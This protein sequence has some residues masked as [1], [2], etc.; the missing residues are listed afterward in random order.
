MDCIVFAMSGEDA[1]RYGR[2]EPAA[3]IP[4]GSKSPT[5][6]SASRSPRCFGWQVATARKPHN[7]L[8]IEFQTNLKLVDGFIG[9][10]DRFYAV[11]AE[12]M[13]GVFHVLLGSSK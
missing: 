10:T 11:P 3:F 7:P 2:A 9:C 6:Q 1:S 5:R 12:I 4:A 13:G 8:L